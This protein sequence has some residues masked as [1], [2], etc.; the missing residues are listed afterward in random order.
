MPRGEGYHLSEVC[1]LEVATRSPSGLSGTTMSPSVLEG[2]TRSPSLLDGA[3][4]S[5]MTH[6]VFQPQYQ[7]AQE[8]PMRGSSQAA[9]PMCT[10][11]GLTFTRSASVTRHMRTHTGEKP[12]HCH[13]CGRGFSRN[14]TLKYHQRSSCSERVTNVESV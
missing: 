4:R 7:S 5:P 14:H 2:T 11:C 12:F 9:P 1:H 13:I 10:V 3:T 6:Y 8:L